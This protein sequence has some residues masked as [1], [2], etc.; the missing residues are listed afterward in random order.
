MVPVSVVIITNNEAEHL[1][2]CIGMARMITDDIIIIDN[3]STDQT[4]AIAADFHCRV[5]PRKWEGYG[6]NKNAGIALARHNWILSLDGD[7]VPDFDLLYALHRVNFDNEGIVY[8]IRFRTYF[9]SKLIRFG[10]WGRDH[11][12]RLFNRNK[13]RWTEPAVHETLILARDIK[14]RRLP[15]YIHHYSVR[16]VA[17]LNH[18]AVYYAGLSAQKYFATGKRAN[19]I[20]LYLSP[21]FVLLKN[22]LVLLGLLDGAEGWQ[23][24]RTTFINR[25]VKYHYLARLQNAAPQKPVI[26]TSFTVEYEAINA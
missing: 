4:L 8:D 23:I 3:G 18:K 19:F 17:E 22:Y 7:E 14:K 20:N 2:A 10:S 24:A 11:H 12:T 16:D 15:G 6:A 1:A 25:W 9:G 21:V 26:K 13:V 5:Y